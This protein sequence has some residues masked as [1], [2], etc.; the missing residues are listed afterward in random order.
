MLIGKAE[1]EG[2]VSV[3]ELFTFTSFPTHPN[4]MAWSVF[5]DSE[6]DCRAH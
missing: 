1:R 5:E 2:G 3:A 4:R 6:E